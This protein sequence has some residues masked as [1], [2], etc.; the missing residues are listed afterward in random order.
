M[1]SEREDMTGAA[2]EVSGALQTEEE[3]PFQIFKVVTE[4]NCFAKS[5]FQ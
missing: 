5:V 3:S 4:E 1:V 2:P